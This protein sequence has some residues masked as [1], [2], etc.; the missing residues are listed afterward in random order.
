MR[1]TTS[2][3][4]FLTNF[5]TGIATRAILREN[6]RR[7]PHLRLESPRGDAC[8]D[9]A[10]VW[11][12]DPLR[13]DRREAAA[14][15]SGS[16]VPKLPPAMY[17]AIID[18]AHK[19]RLRVVAH[20]FDLADAKELLRAGIDGFAH[21]VRDRDV[22]DEFMALITARPDVWVI[23]NLPERD[24][25]DDYAW[26]SDTVPAARD[27]A[28]AQ[29]RGD[30]HAAPRARQARELYEVQA[31]NL[32][33]LNAAGVRIGLRH[34]RRGLGRLERAAPSWPTWSRPGMTP[35]QVLDGGDRRPRPR[36]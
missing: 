23:P 32:A 31:R 5:A 13:R 3:R 35:A 29:G 22:D 10:I 4:L 27:R 16:T 7:L 24:T 20:I 11:C 17:R 2:T 18:E 19:Q 36:S 33:R 9:T 8:A 34:R 26:L 12:A 30:T 25:G 15:L 6:L 21:G 28:A 1:P 14:I